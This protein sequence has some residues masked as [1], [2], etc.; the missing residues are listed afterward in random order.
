M[1][2][3]LKSYQTSITLIKTGQLVW[4]IIAFILCYPLLN[5]VHTTSDLTE[6][7][8]YIMNCQ[9]VTQR[10]IKSHLYPVASLG[11]YISSIVFVSALY[12]VLH[13][14]FY[15]LHACKFDTRDIKTSINQSI[16]Q[17]KTCV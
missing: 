10:C 11:I 4:P 16:N 9:D 5:H 12:T 14:M 7:H 2:Q 6:I 13:T 1:L 17:S 8:V 3:H 15:Q